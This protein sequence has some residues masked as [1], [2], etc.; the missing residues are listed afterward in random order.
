MSPGCAQHAVLTDVM[1]RGACAC[2]RCNPALIGIDSSKTRKYKYKDNKRY[3]CSTQLKHCSFVHD[4][5][6]HCVQSFRQS[7]HVHCVKSFRQSFDGISL[8]EKEGLKVFQ[9]F[10]FMLTS[11]TL[12]RF[13]H[14]SVLQN[15]FVFDTWRCLRDHPSYLQLID[16]YR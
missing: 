8:E 1:L 3:T 11:K 10:L 5:H 15:F 4:F 9:N 2:V 7:L 12:F 16:H 14:L 6:M 13:N